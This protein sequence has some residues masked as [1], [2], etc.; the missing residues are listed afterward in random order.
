[1]DC[2]RTLS[3]SILAAVVLTGAS[4]RAVSCTTQAEMKEAERTAM[5]NAVN[6]LAAKVQAGDVAAVKAMTI[7]AVASNFAGIAASIQA[8]TPLLGGATL[9]V[10]SLYDLQAGD[11]KPNQDEVEFFCGEAANAPHVTFT[12]PQLPPGHYAFIVVQATGV[13]QPQRLSFLLENKGSWQLAGF[14]P[15]PLLSAGH[16]GVW[17]WQ[18]A[19]AFSKAG[20]LWDAY[21]YYQTAAYLLLPADFVGSSNFEKLIQEQTAATPAGLPGAQPMTVNAGDAALQITNLHTDSSFGGLD[22]VV[23]Y[24]T[25]DVS[26]P[27]RARTK[28]V[29]LMKALLSLHPELKEGFHG[30]W[31]F[32]H[33]PGQPPFALELPMP[34][35][36][37]QT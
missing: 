3:Y 9:N 4:A 20:Q 31:V 6:G 10:T 12:I 2:F 17:Y 18:K 5:V 15:R 32:A 24:D 22:L 13:K 7:P 11:A 19:R 26:D 16:D 27:A 33:A 28:T 30:L 21:F 14:F 36:A 35:I 37:T 23:S 29:A 25:P 8:L 34:E 1:M